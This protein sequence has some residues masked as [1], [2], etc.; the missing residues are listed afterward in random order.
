[1]ATSLSVSYPAPALGTYLVRLLLK[2]AYLN[3]A[4]LAGTCKNA[5]YFR[6]AKSKRFGYLLLC[7]A[8]QIIVPGHLDIEIFNKIG[9]CHL[10][11]NAAMPL[12]MNKRLFAYRCISLIL[13]SSFIRNAR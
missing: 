7:L 9:I 6:T 8:L 4:V 5:Q 2:A 12:W 3:S 1:M 13:I 10:P 11:T